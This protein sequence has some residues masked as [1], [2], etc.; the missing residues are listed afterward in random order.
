MST[1]FPTSLDT[2]PAAATLAAENLDDSPHSTLHGN[3]GDSV[4]ALEAKVGVDGSAVTASHDYLLAQLGTAA[5]ADLLDEDNMAS[6]SATDAASQQS[7]KAY[8]DAHIS[9][10]TAAHAASAISFDASGLS[11]TS[12]TDVQNAIGD[13]D[14]AISAGGATQLDGLSDVTL[15]T[16]SSGDLLRYNGSAWVNYPDSNFVTKA[17]FDA[18]TI[19]YATTDNTPAALTVTEETV[20]GRLTGGAIAAVNPSAIA[21]QITS[22]TSSYEAVLTDRGKII[23]M[24]SSS[25]L[26]LTIPSNAGVA[27]PTGTRIDLAQVSGGTITVTGSVGVTI[28]YSS[29]L[30]K[31]T[32]GTWSV[33]T[34]YKRGTDEWVLAGD[35]TPA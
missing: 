21:Q 14:G 15:T 8:V 30:T 31:V 12:A 20:A 19:L 27:Y 28:R 26:T 18:Y 13:L 22:V 33:A 17:L 9:D 1:N 7:I 32:N 3:L 5:N 10:A 2:F 24:S 34:L 35:L 4:A 16:E 29:N 25:A 23:E 6:N 11:N